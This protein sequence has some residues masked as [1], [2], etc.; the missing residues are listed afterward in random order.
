MIKYVL[1]SLLFFIISCQNTTTT[2]SDNIENNTEYVNVFLKDDNI[3]TYSDNKTP[4]LSLILFGMDGCSSCQKMYRLISKKG[5]TSTLIQNNYLPYY[6]N[7]SR[8]KV[9]IMNE[10]IISLEKL[11]NRFIMVGVPVFVIMYGDKKLFTYTGIMEENML[12]IIIDFF[13]NKKVYDLSM[14]EIEQMLRERLKLNNI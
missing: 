8:K 9:W 14:Q 7:I 6:I 2:S 4:S 11:K 10:H 3:R 13:L 1:T 5:D 12:Y